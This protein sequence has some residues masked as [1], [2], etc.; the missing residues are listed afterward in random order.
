MSRVILICGSLRLNQTFISLLKMNKQKDYCMECLQVNNAITRLVDKFAKTYY[1]DDFQIQR[2]DW[3][4]DC[5]HY[6]L[7]INDDYWNIDEIYTAL[8]Y[9]IPKEILFK[10]YDE[11]LDKALK[12]ETM[13]N[14][15]NFYLMKKGEDVK[16]K[17]KD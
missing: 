6:N 9:D 17:W 14:L 10:Y 13:P 1:W 15:K 3:E 16:W 12:H 4:D 7:Q 8:R 5:L 2:I 11:R